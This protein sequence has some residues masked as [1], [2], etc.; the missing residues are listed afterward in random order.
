MWGGVVGDVTVEGGELRKV[1]GR[2]QLTEMLYMNE[3]CNEVCDWVRVPV[4]KYL[5]LVGALRRIADNDGIMHGYGYT[6]CECSSIAH[7][8]L[9]ESCFDHEQIDEER[10]NNGL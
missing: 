5:S 9:E 4:K 6:G 2:M 10:T 8:A 7:E 1:W 3:Q